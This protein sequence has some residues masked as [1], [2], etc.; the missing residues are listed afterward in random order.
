M[1][2]FF[3]GGGEECNHVYDRRHYL[4]YFKR[5]CV[6]SGICQVKLN[7]LLKNAKNVKN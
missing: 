6:F 7:F 3:W 4:S 1:S 2:E 5:F